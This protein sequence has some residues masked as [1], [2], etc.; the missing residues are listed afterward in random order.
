MESQLDLVF[1]SG[2]EAF[3]EAESHPGIYGIGDGE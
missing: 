1:A 2:F 3:P